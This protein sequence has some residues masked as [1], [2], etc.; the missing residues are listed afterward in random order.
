MDKAIITPFFSSKLTHHMR[1]GAGARII[2][3]DGAKAENVSW[4]LGTTLTVGADMVFEGSILAG[5]AIVF[6]A[7]TVVEGSIQVRV[8][9]PLP[10]GTVVVCEGHL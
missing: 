10:W 3:T 1:M 9:H 5:T 6:G 7:G 2:L 4:A 8:H